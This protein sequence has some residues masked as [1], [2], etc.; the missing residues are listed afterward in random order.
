MVGAGCWELSRANLWECPQAQ[1]SSSRCLL[2]LA[3]P[4][5]APGPAG[6]S[7]P[8]P[9]PVKAPNRG[10]PT[11][12]T[13]S[14]PVGI[15]RVDIVESRCAGQGRPWAVDSKPA[16]GSA[17]CAQRSAVHSRMPGSRRRLFQLPT[18]R[19]LSIPAF[20]RSN[21]LFSTPTPPTAAAGLWA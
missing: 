5:L 17:G 16:A 9:C 21:A 2:A 3:A 20:P 13:L 19:F 6:P 15:G 11:L 8:C 14:P 7:L 1:P 12:T 10:S 18:L 4:V